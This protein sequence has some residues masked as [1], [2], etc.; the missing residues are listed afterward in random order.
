M[1]SEAA[2]TIRGES[3][4]GGRSHLPAENRPSL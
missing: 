3:L 2:R 1:V 4:G